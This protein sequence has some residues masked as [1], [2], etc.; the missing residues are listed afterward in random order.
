MHDRT[1]FV[2]G[3]TGLIGKSLTRLLCERAEYRNVRIAVRQTFDFRHPKLTQQT[4]DFNRMEELLDLKGITDVFCTLGT[5]IGKAGSREGFRRVDFEY[6]I[7][8]ARCA[9]RDGVQRML[10]VSST[11][12]NPLSGNFYLRTKGEVE[13][14][15]V[16]TFNGAIHLFRPSLLLG[17]RSEF[18]FGERIGGALMTFMSF[19][20]V[21]RFRNYRPI[22][23]SDVALGMI[24]AALSDSEGVQRYESGRIVELAGAHSTEISEQR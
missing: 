20:M 11:G 22:K 5:T 19:M 1:A 17:E 7:S 23:A 9:D 13:V 15:L 21:G 3:A 18:R 8:L 4:L 2:A 12:A 16:K 14:G 24:L 10:L 6:P